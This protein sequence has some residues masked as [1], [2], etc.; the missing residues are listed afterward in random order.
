MDRASFDRAALQDA[1]PYRII[2]RD[3]RE[4]VEMTPEDFDDLCRIHLCDWLEQVGRSQ[5]WD[6]RQAAYRRLA[7]RL[8]GIAEDTHRRIWG[9]AAAAAGV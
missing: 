2:I 9:Q 7:E 4:G 3:T 8:G 6:Y 5:R 1:G